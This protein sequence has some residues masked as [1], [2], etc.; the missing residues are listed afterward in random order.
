MSK[1]K[2]SEST[3]GAHD[4]KGSTTAQGGKYRGAEV[5]KGKE[6]NG[7]R[8]NAGTNLV[9]G[10]SHETDVVINTGIP[11]GQVHSAHTK[12]RGDRLAIE[13]KSR[14]SADVA[15]GAAPTKGAGQKYNDTKR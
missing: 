9:N 5:R 11:L 8:P 4:R 1:D 2:G 12:L 13:P 10:K 14:K 6:E 15:S 3:M 7:A